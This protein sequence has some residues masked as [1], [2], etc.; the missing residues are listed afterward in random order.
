MACGWR[1]CRTGAGVGGPPDP[2]PDRV[3]FQEAAGL[4]IGG[5]TAYEGSV[6]RGAPGRRIRAHHGRRGGVGSVAVQIAAA[7]GVRPLG[8]ASPPNHDYLRGLGASEV[9]DYHANDLAYG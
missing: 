7:V 4:V 2:L 5:G 6:D 9:F 1:V 8:V 3:S